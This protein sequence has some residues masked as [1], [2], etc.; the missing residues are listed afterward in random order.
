MRID[1]WYENEAI[2]AA[3]VTFYPG[4]CEYRGNLYNKEGRVI[5]DFVS[6]DSTE[7]ERRFPGIFGE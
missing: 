6:K 2:A 1:L 5:G 7:V 4:N 3:T